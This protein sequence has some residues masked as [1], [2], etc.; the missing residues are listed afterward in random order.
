LAPG[1]LVF[2]DHGVMRIAGSDVE[3][4]WDTPVH[5]AGDDGAGGVLVYAEPGTTLRLAAGGESSTIATNASPRFVTLFEGRPAVMVSQIGD[6][7]CGADEQ[8][9][10]LIDPITADRTAVAPCVPLG[11]IGEHPASTGE[12]V[13]LHVMSTFDIEVIGVTWLEFRDLTTGAPID[14]PA[15]PWPDPCQACALG[16][17]LSPDGNLLALT[18]FTPGPADLGVESWEAFSA[19]NPTSRWQAWEEARAM[20]WTQIRVVDL[21][22][23]TTRWED[24]AGGPCSILDFDGRHLVWRFAGMGHHATWPYNTHLV[25]VTTGESLEIHWPGQ[26]DGSEQQ[27]AL[28]LPS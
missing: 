11:A 23:G 26:P 27:I 7:G 10:V 5:W 14:L 3:T 17:R 25:D 22:D 2:G 21:S 4:V 20:G 12:S 19:M 16:G 15:N 24:G 28:L 18:E 8:S 6:P 9:S 13:A 1:Y